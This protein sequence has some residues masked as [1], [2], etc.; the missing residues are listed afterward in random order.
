[1]LSAWFTIAMRRIHLPDLLAIAVDW[2]LWV[3]MGIS[4]APLVGT[5]LLQGLKKKFEP[6]AG[7]LKTTAVAYNQTEADVD[8]DCRGL[9]YV[10]PTI[11]DARISDM[12]G[13]D[14]V[15]NA[16]FVD[17]GKVQMFFF[18]MVAALVYSVLLYQSL[19]TSNAA[20]LTSLPTLRRAC[21]PCS[22]SATSA[23]SA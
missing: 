1:M 16:A 7:T 9:M 18:T 19:D 22:G 4:T 12:F 11:D 14:E 23:T 13:G 21:S 5:P 3:L 10:N 17:L 8:A 15:G 6:K 20:D 2:H